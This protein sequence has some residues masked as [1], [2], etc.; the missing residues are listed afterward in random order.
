M[1]VTNGDAAS[2][3]DLVNLLSIPKVELDKFD[4]NPL[5]YQSFIESTSCVSKNYW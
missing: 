5:D 2:T 4:G 3:A 1:S